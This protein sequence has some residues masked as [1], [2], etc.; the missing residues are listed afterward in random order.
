[1]V[2]ADIAS[3]GLYDVLLSTRH[4]GGLVWHLLRTDSVKGIAEHFAKE[5]R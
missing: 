3:R 2:Y 1:M 4:F 5:E